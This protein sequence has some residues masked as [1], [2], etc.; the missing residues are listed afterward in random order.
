[1]SRLPTILIAMAIGATLAVGCSSPTEPGPISA[2]LPAGPG[3]GTVARMAL[4]RAPLGI[5]VADEGFA[6]ITQPDHGFSGGTLA[7]VD[8]KGRTVTATIP[9]GR[10][11]SLVI[12]NAERTR[13]YVSN[14]WSDNI[15]IVDVASG[16]QIDTIPTVGDPFA[17]AL[18][19][20][21]GSLLVTTNANRLFKIDLAT[22]RIL[23]S[24]ALPATSHHILMAPRDESLLN[25]HDRFLYVATRDGGSVMEVNWRQ[26]TVSRTFTL[27]GRPQDMAFSPNGEELY[28]ANEVSNVL[29]V[30]D[31]ATG[32][33]TNIPLAGGGEGLA[34]GNDGNAIYVG[35]VFA[36]AVQVIDR[37]DGETVRLIP[38]G[39]VPREI[40]LDYTGR[41][42]L[43][44]NEDGWVD[45]IEPNDSLVPPPPPPPPPDTGYTR[46]GLSDGAL[47][48]AVSGDI[49][50][51]TRPY[52]NMVARLDLRTNSVTPS[53][54]V[55]NV[56]CYI[57]FNSTGT[58]AYEANQ[59][60]DNVSVIDVAT[61]TQIATIPLTGDPL[62]VAISTD[63]HTLFVTTNAN[64][65]FKVDLATNTVTGSL[66]LPA[67][68]HHLLTHPNGDLVYVATRDGG[69]VLEVN[70][71]TMTVVRTFFLGARPQGMAI[72]ADQSELY[73][74]NELSDVLHVITLS[75]GAI[76]NVPLAGG[77][78]GMS[79]GADGKLYV[80]EVFSGLV[81]VVDP[82]TRTV[83]RTITM[84]G[85]PREVATDAERHHVLVANEG[86]WVDI[87]R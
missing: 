72:A 61:N 28:V 56:P 73:V 17:L 86:G 5:A 27:S 15:G 46:V 9:V 33:F 14:Q 24:I 53:F 22:K 66:A 67:T 59:F 54:P 30:I 36:G 81:Q 76:T 18:S 35:L 84:G 50:Y 45:F 32:T 31:L 26:M 85:T 62:P 40:A 1:M 77:G 49:A 63:D 69:T 11:P 55:G 60:S 23:G 21:G 48:V 58:R 25:L 39:G 87:I 12:F 51:V 16:T 80:G 70:W 20:D 41:D 44:S 83:V 74:A 6:Y 82:A 42:V 38:V 75:S 68:S 8:L 71:H 65:L 43:V 2:S 34:L 64:Q 4:P 10:V 29:H 47:G 19:P 78:E 37:R 57:V 3:D 13:A 7:R 52:A 79:L